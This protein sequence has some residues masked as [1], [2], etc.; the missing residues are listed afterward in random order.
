MSRSGYS[1]DCENVWLWRRAVANAIKGKRGQA[2]LAE[3]ATALDEMPVRA[4]AAD[5]LVT[6]H[7]EVCALGALGAKRG[8]DM[9][10]IDPDEPAYVAEAFGIAPAMAQEIVYMND[11]RGSDGRYIDGKWTVVHETPEGRWARMRAWV[12]RQ[13]VSPANT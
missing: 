8:L 7:G 3:L 12:A 10:K 11:E 6:A 1:D 9:S 4:L 5:S 13:I 2:M